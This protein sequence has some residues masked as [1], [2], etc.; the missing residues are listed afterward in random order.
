MTDALKL[1]AEDG[2]LE[3]VRRLI[4]TQNTPINQPDEFGD[5]A[6]HAAVAKGRAGVVT[7]LLEHGADP[8]IQNKAGSTTLHKVA[9]AKYD[10]L[11]ILRLLI[12]HKANPLIRN[13]AGLLPEQLGSGLVK[14]LLAGNDYV[15][16]ELEVPK[17]KHGR[18]IGKKGSKMKEIQTDTGTHVNVP[19][20]EDGSNK[21]TI[22]GRQEAVAK[23]K[24]LI[25]ELLKDKGPGGRGGYDDDENDGRM[26]T[27]LNIPKD[28][29]RLIIGRG[30]AT[31]N[32]IR[33][34]TGVDIIIP[35]ADSKDDCIIIKGDTQDDISEAIKRIEEIAGSAPPRGGGGGGGGRRGSN[36]SGGGGGGRS[37][38]DGYRGGGGG[39]GGGQ[40][41][42]NGVRS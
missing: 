36:S 42:S 35:P 37:T 25:L 15:V 3:E 9:V 31:V 13:S 23:A 40:R 19:K 34:E 21:I 26:S 8:N 14:E 24:E 32:E 20:Q 7:Y 41:G 18:I 33:E 12:K 38:P 6:L 1:A 27:K 4:E 5:T 17:S 2:D 11:S 39:G 22:K 29:H 30:G 16:E 28:R 10:Q